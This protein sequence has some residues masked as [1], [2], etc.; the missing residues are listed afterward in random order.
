VRR[1]HPRHRLE[2]RIRAH[3]I[4]CWLALLMVR[5]V[6]TATGDTWNRIREEQ[7]LHVGTSKDPPAHSASAPSCNRA[8]RVSSG[9]SSVTILDHPA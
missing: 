1:A 9:S 3:V 6:E 4:L 8:A 2:D 5:I 7:E